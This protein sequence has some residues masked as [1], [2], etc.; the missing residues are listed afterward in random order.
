MSRFVQE[1]TLLENIC[2]TAKVYLLYKGIAKTTSNFE[3]AK[4]RMIFI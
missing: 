2:I 4:V 1:V 3:C